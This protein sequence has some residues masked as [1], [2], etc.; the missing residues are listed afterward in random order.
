MFDDLPDFAL[1]GE[2]GTDIFQRLGDEGQ[3][4]ARFRCVATVADGRVIDHLPEDRR[5]PA[6]LLALAARIEGDPLSR[7]LS[8]TDPQGW[9]LAA[10]DG[11]PIR[12]FLHLEFLRAWQVA[13][14]A[15]DRLIRQVTADPSAL[16]QEP[17]KLSGAVAPLMEFNRLSRAVDLARLAVPVLARR[18]AAPGFAD[19]KGGNTG[20]ALRMLGD[21]CLRRAEAALAL[22]CFETAVA[23]GDNPFRRR[24]AIEAAVAAGD[25]EAADRHRTAFA[26]RW[27]LPDDLKGPA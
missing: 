9:P 13:D 22:T 27:R 12:L 18:L 1:R 6:R 23:A 3:R 8:L 21:L 7:P 4:R 5:D 11:D 19:D 17:G 20:F 15:A 25:A 10:R 14:L 24:R 2:C 26:A 16:P